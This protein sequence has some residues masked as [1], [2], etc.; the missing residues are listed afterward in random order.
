MEFQ[1][2]RTPHRCVHRAMSLEEG[3]QLAAACLVKSDTNGNGE[4]TT[5]VQ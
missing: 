1:V 3:D 2:N 4:K 5:L